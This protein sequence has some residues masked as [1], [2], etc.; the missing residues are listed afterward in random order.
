MTKP[1]NTADSPN[2]IAKA[3]IYAKLARLGIATVLITYD[4]CGDS[5]CIG[6]I[7]ARG[8]NGETVAL[9]KRD[10]TIDFVESRWDTATSKF[11]KVDVRLKL[12]IEKAVE[13]WCYD[14]L[15]HHFGGWEINEGSQGTIALDIVKNIATLEHD[16]NVMTTTTHTV[17]V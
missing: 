8:P 16:E 5:G 12:P 7:D 14:L 4:G 11:V 2:E 6:S 3:Q 13:S 10:I 9:P 15:E 17:V 1:T